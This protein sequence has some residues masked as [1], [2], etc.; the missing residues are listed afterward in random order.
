MNAGNQPTSVVK[1]AF[2]P[3][4]IDLAIEQIVPLKILRPGIKDSKKYAQIRGSVKAIGLVEA[5]V[6]AR[7][8]DNAASFFLLDGH[9]RI[10]CL[11][12][13]GI[14]R[15]ECLV[16]TDDETYT[17]N[18]RINRLAAVQEHN[19]IKRAIARG[20]PDAAI[21]EALGL[22]VKTIV[23]RTRLVNGICPEAV[24]ILKDAS[25]PMAVFDLLRRMSAMRQV[26]AAEL[27]AGQHN[28]SL[29]FAKAL[30]AATPDTAMAVP[31]RKTPRR[32]GQVSAEQM[33]KMERELAS[34][35]T[36]VKSFEENYGLDTLHLTVARG[37]IRKLLG[38][39]KVVSW[40]GRHRGEY[41]GE[42]RAITDVDG[43]GTAQKIG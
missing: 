33:A 38:N 5:P 32:E 30:L 31:R 6:V 22:D 25:T 36:Q 40:L 35:Q 29:Q 42:F 39:P 15:V 17:Y 10:E 18:K 1:L 9:L 2:E 27:M 20:V 24:E 8:P 7:N 4:T 37:Y 19:M 3:D 43:E 12:D 23:R 26:E 16:S 13:L 11:K 41:L 21:A 14:L 28:Y 34:L